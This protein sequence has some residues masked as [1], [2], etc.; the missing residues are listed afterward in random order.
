[1]GCL[2][3]PIPSGIHCWIETTLEKLSKEKQASGGVGLDRQKIHFYSLGIL[4]GLI[5]HTSIKGQKFNAS[6][7]GKLF[8][9]GDVNRITCTATAVAF[10]NL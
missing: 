3:P 8:S 10:T 1:M 4:G 9:Q 5:H 7:L 2:A 6:I